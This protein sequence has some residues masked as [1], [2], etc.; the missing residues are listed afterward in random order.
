MRTLS[1]CAILF[2]QTCLLLTVGAPA[3][4]IDALVE[5]VKP[6]ARFMDRQ[7]LFTV[8]KEPFRHHWWNSEKKIVPMTSE[9]LVIRDGDRIVGHIAGPT[10]NWFSGSPPGDEA[11]FLDPE[12]YAPEDDSVR[13][14]GRLIGGLAG[15]TLTMFVP[16]PE[17]DVNA[18]ITPAA[19][20]HMDPFG[21]ALTFGTGVQSEPRVTSTGKTVTAEWVGRAR[22]GSRSTHQLVLSVDPLAFVAISEAGDVMG[23][24]FTLNDPQTAAQ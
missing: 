13:H 22:N 15:T 4:E 11:P 2:T 19:W 9:R 16:Q 18:L 23:R 6:P 1:T 12:R 8:R 21:C 10:V 7:T 5:K 14:G 17:E 3:D 20:N 24:G